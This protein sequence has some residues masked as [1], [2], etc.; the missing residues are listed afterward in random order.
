MVLSG[1][2]R[3]GGWGSGLVWVSLVWGVGSGLG[4]YLGDIQCSPGRET[5]RSSSIQV[6]GHYIK[7]YWQRCFLTGYLSGILHWFSSFFWEKCIVSPK[8]EVYPWHAVPQSDPSQT[9]ITSAVAVGKCSKMGLRG[10]IHVRMSQGIKN[11]QKLSIYYSFIHLLP[12]DTYLYTASVKMLLRVYR[13]W[14]S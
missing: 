8:I 14:L 4:S 7:Q 6:T 12:V 3:S 10:A 2:V 9:P 13:E 5:S 11:F 1:W